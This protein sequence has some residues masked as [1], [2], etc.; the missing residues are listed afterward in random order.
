[1][2]QSLHEFIE[3]IHRKINVLECELDRLQ[4]M[5]RRSG[6]PRDHYT[7]EQTS[8]PEHLKAA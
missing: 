2:E 8:T 4:D 5:N 6:A 7:A 3:E 1:M